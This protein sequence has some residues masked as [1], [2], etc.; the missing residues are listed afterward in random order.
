MD[1]LPEL[2]QEVELVLELSQLQVKGI[3]GSHLGEQVEK[4]LNLFDGD[5]LGGGLGQPQLHGLDVRL[6]GLR[7]LALLASPQA[8][9]YLLDAL[10]Q[11]L[12]VGDHFDPVG[13]HL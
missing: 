5:D 1:A 10:D 9:G 12:V 11:G 8:D 4:V 7:C 6:E 3:R 2:A 13:V